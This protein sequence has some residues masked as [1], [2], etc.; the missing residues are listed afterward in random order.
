M[1]TQGVVLSDRY[2]LSERIATGGMG[3]VW[4][5]TDTLLDRAVAV[6][7]LLPSLVADPEF[8]TRFHAEARMLAALRHPGIVQV[9]DFGSATLADGSQVSYLVME[10]VDGEPLVTWIRRAGRLDPASTM[11]VVAQAAQALH[12]AHLA[13]IV[14]RDVKP[15]NLLVKRDGTVVLV[16]F[17]IARASTMAG[18]TAAHMV[19]GTASYMSPE[20]AA[21][22]PVSAATD[23]YALGVVAYF[24][25]AGRPPFEGDNPLQVAMRHVQD[26]P[27]PLPQGTPPAVVE[28]V[29]RS[30][31]KRAGD[32]YPSGLAMAEAAQDARDVTLARLPVP[33]R[34]PWAVAGPAVPGPAALPT[35][36]PPA[37]PGPAT[38]CQPG[39]TPSGGHPLPASAASPAPVSAVDRPSGANPAPGS[40]PDARGPS[41]VG[42][43]PATGGNV[44]GSGPA[45]G[46]NVAGSGP[47]TGG[48]VAGSGP[49]SGGA[50]QG[51]APGWAAPGPGA[52]FGGPAGFAPPPAAPYPQPTAGPAGSV[53]GA[54]PRPGGYGPEQDR[55][56]GSG[57]PP[58]LEE[59]AGRR[60][61]RGRVIALAGTAAVVLVAVVIAVSV[62]ALRHS[63]DPNPGQRPAALAG[64]SAVADPPGTEPLATGEPPT[65]APSRTGRD[66]RSP[67]AAP[68]RS[69]VTTGPSTGGPAPTGG[70]TGAPGPA[71]T[72]SSAAPQQP[73]PYTAKQVC[74]SGYQVVDSAT[75]TANGVR[76]GR[77]YLLYNTTSGANCVV[78]MKDTD[79]G[80]A[81]TVS[82][83]LEVQG[84][85]RNTDS[86]AYKYY[87]G[88][89][90][91]SAAGVCVKWGGSTGGASY[92]SPF[93]H[94]G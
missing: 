66:G 21:G 92:G 27:P 44:A 46:G 39:G 29:R 60:P 88:P 58:T 55:H 94:C 36:G 2:L 4:K 73:N 83:Y 47:A 11:S 33:P 31:A 90:R 9:H 63:D 76:K 64:E 5:C 77:V 91:A 24:C 68:S 48:N 30:L 17:G 14:H 37:A 62:T 50:A 43:G 23:V 19:L 84:K 80:R 53:G 49:A 82:T 3:A 1:L 13:G 61:G 79:V 51:F 20:Q 54:G 26:E 72:T 93:E 28:V 38:P 22:Q 57:V 12:T 70:S 7:V 52:G 15:G 86:A 45:T 56:A 18:I 65:A 25:L 41:P 59:S 74:G 75:L 71:P 67:S 78:T 6:K 89:V 35:P 81:T 85:A 16:D 69:A 87:A 42:T 10:Y 32:R 34:P 40:A 8:T